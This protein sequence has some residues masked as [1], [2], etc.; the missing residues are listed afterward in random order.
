MDIY[1]P[2][3]PPL[4]LRT[5]YLVVPTEAQEGRLYRGVRLKPLCINSTREFA[6]PRKSFVFYS[7]FNCEQR[8]KLV[9]PGHMPA[10][11]RHLERGRRRRDEADAAQRERYNDHRR[12]VQAKL[13]VYKTVRPELLAHLQQDLVGR[14]RTV[15]AVVK[16]VANY[17]G[18]RDKFRVVGSPPR[19]ATIHSGE[20]V[21]SNL[22]FAQLRTRADQL[23][24]DSGALVEDAALA[25]LRTMAAQAE[26]ARMQE[27]FALQN[28]AGA[29]GEA[30]ASLVLT[31]EEEAAIDSLDDAL[32]DLSALRGFAAAHFETGSAASTICRKLVSL[33]KGI[34][35]RRS[36]HQR[37]SNGIRAP[38]GVLLT[39][40]GVP[41]EHFEAAEQV[42]T[43]LLLLHRR[44]GKQM[45][46]RRNVPHPPTRAVIPDLSIYRDLAAAL[47]RD[48]LAF[49]T[50]A[51]AWCIVNRVTL[52]LDAFKDLL[53][54]TITFLECVAVPSRP[55]PL[56]TITVGQWSAARLFAEEQRNAL[57]EAQAR[58]GP[59]VTGDTLLAYMCSD[60]KRSATQ[61][62]S[63]QFA[64][65]PRVLS[66][67]SIYELCRQGSE[68]SNAPD[69]CFWVHFN[70]FPVESEQLSSLVTRATK[71]YTGEAI[72]VTTLRKAHATALAS[73]DVARFAASVSALGSA[74]GATHSPRC[75]QAPSSRPKE[76]DPTRE[77]KD[78]MLASVYSQRKAFGAD[79]TD[80]AFEQGGGDIG[81][82]ARSHLRHYV[83]GSVGAAHARTEKRL[84]D[85]LQERFGAPP[86]PLLTFGKEGRCSEVNG[87]DAVRLRAMLSASVKRELLSSRPAEDYVQRC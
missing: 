87:Q 27:A 82:G 77:A 55:L 67:L 43:E 28:G 52:A 83:D 12:A 5:S 34:A 24:S 35:W 66:V 50:T 16:D 46:A 70:G 20:Q 72:G 3:E 18:S 68:A 15:V 54:A 36:Y 13:K 37:I 21:Q 69:A 25:E 19:A 10:S 85:T 58:G 41:M 29:E 56:A 45:D 80:K 81:H 42:V 64:I 39:V 9:S 60:E 51:K 31:A 86:P 40:T 74:G 62:G 61:N 79:Q 49:A 76:A 71:W 63:H 32:V 8:L 22:L 33:A 44:Q 7:V 26:R 17:I 65:T 47:E 57:L 75:Q 14:P 2:L 1:G 73:D 59:V 4:A 53:A 23:Q 6:L 11:K 30:C 78:L 38:N 48:I 84:A